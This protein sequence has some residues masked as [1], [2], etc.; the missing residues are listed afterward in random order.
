MP[1]AWQPASKERHIDASGYFSNRTIVALTTPAGGALCGLRISG[2]SAIAIGCSLSGLQLSHEDHRRA[3]RVWLHDEKG[4]R[5][6]EC[7]M[8][9]FFAP[10]S[11]TGEDAV[12]M[13]LHGSPMIAQRVLE[14]CFKLGARLALPGEFSFRAVKNGKLQI[15]QAEAIK[16]VIA[17]SND[18]SLDLAL[19]K[20]AGS[21]H[22]LVGAVKNELMQVCSLSEAGIDF[23]DQDIEEVSLPRLKAR[24]NKVREQLEALRGSF[25]RGKRFNEGVPVSIFGLPNAGKSSF[26][27][28]LLG[29]DRSIVSDIAG[30]TRDVVREKIN[31]RGKSGQVTLRLS[32]TAGLRESSDVIEG[33]GIERSLRAAEESDIVVV[34]IDGLEPHFERVKA[35]LDLVVLAGKAFV[36]VISK[37]DLL[38]NEA[39]KELTDGVFHFFQQNAYF[40]SSNSLEGVRDVADGLAA[41]AGLQLIRKPGEVV[42]TQMEHVR[43]V[44]S[45]LEILARAMVASDLVLFANDVRHAMNALGPLIGETL[46]DDVL[47]KI[48]SDFCIGK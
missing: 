45:S 33:I 44:E 29:E 39:R 1:Q 47:G 27:N 5:L 7:L 24:L 8:L 20:L 14:E 35:Y 6:D 30:T 32:D 12:E 46:P 43:A 3:K 10:H 15:S 36:F 38:T 19:E 11:F 9:A 41:C 28:A 16:E 21:Q 18:F 26:F 2:A 22:Q 25:D 48:F 34:V 13:F 31:L 4:A 23:S 37:L 40:I 17:A 42:L